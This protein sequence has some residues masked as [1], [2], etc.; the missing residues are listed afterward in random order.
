M[1]SR[2]ITAVTIASGATDI[3]LQASD[4]T[5]AKATLST[6]TYWHSDDGTSSDLLAE[7][8]SAFE[9]ALVG[10]TFTVDVVGMGST[11][12]NSPYGALRIAIDSGEFTLGWGIAGT[13]LDPRILGWPTDYATS[14]SSSSGVLISDYVHAGG[15][16]PRTAPLDPYH[17]KYQNEHVAVRTVGGHIDS[18]QVYNW[19]RWMLDFPHVAEALASRTAGLDSLRAGDVDVTV[20]DEFASFESWV[21]W[22]VRTDADS[23]YYPDLSDTSEYYGPLKLP[24]GSTQREEPL[25]NQYVQR[26]PDSMVYAIGVE[27]DEVP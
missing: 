12:S 21:N 18:A 25:S 27:L 1:E 10:S 6:G 16:Y 4:Y 24:A 11:P 15:W 23:R 2:L 17:A 26:L 13:T 8:K 14:E 7:I 22:A 5:N 19:R 9:A 20:G 3:Q